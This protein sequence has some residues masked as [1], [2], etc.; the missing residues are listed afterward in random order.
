M[1]YCVRR[2]TFQSNKFI[3]DQKIEL[4]SNYDKFGDG[5][6]RHDILSVGIKL[7]RV[8]SILVFLTI[9]LWKGVIRFHKRRM[10]NSRYIGPF[11]ILKRIRPIAYRLELPPKLNRIHNVFMCLGWENI[12]QIPLMFWKFHLLNS[13]K[14]CP[15][16]CNQ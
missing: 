7:R 9:V 15:S 1:V 5:G 12:F 4:H 14:I 2:G 13:K 10:L 3:E 8:M 6:M 11:R 16:K